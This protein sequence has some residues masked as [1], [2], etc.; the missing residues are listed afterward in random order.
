VDDHP[1]FRL[2]LK[3]ALEREPDLEIT[4]E[5]DSA[6]NLDSV[7][8]STPVDMVFIDI[9]LGG[10]GKDGLAVTRAVVERWP[11]VKIAAISASLDA[12]VSI[13]STR[14][15]ADVFLR[16][17]M[18]ISEMVSAVRKLAAS[19]P[20]IPAR[21]R[22]RSASPSGKQ[23]K[24]DALSPRQRQVFEYL[25]AGRTNREIAA[26]LGVSVATVNKHVHE[27]LT[28]LEVRNRTEAV[29]AVSRDQD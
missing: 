29:T 16:K 19:E 17:A 22:R 20:P 12:Q 27:V 4:W 14:A 13:D 23:S 8:R 28:V 6:T 26:R 1:I 5:L 11:D 21:P 2:G 24:L 25:K 7:M 3:R 18:P 10:H 15:G 9:Y